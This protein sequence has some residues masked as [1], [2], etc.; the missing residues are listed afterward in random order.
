[1]FGVQCPINS[2]SRVLKN[3]SVHLYNHRSNLGYIT[4][5]SNFILSITIPV[6]ST[7]K[8]NEILALVNQ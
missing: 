5:C 4:K 2:N 6:K 1:M 3:L 7:K 8:W